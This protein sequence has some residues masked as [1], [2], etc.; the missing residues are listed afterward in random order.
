MSLFRVS[1]DSIILVSTFY[2]ICSIYCLFELSDLADC[3]FCGWYYASICCTLYST[4]YALC[5]SACWI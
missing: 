1:I 5:H 2:L 4:S 3:A